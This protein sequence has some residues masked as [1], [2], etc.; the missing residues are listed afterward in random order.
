MNNSKIDIMEGTINFWTNAQ[1]VQFADNEV[2]CLFEGNSPDGNI[3][4]VKDRDNK[5]K[6]LHEYRGKGK[7][8]VEYDV[9]GLDPNKRHMI[10]GTWSVKNKELA[11]Y[12]DGQK[13]ASS[14]I[15]YE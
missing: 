3:S 9:S 11:L 1:K 2:T 7:T 8:G 4:I 13:V 12:V 10:T 15:N 6:F 14:K 5:L